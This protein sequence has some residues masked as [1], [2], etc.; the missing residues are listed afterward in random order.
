MLSSGAGNRASNGW[1]FAPETSGRQGAIDNDFR[2]RVVCAIDGIICNDASEALYFVA[3]NDVDGKVLDGANRYTLRFEKD[4]MPQVR[5]FCSLTMCDPAHNLDNPI[6]RYALRDRMPLKREPDGR[7]IV[8]LQPTSPGPDKEPNWLPSPIAR[9]PF[10]SHS[11]I[12]FPSDVYRSL[13]A[14]ARQKKVSLA[15]VWSV[16]PPQYVADKAVALVSVGTS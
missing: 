13:E 12:S 11:P 2:G 6:N 4:G 16:R 8:Y 15:W 1:I 10:R 3:F 9:N 14:L 5:E 7:M